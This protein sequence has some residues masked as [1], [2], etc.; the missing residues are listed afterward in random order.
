MACKWIV[1]K[2][3][4][5]PIEFR[6]MLAGLPLEKQLVNRI[7][8]LIALKAV[9]SESY[10]HQGEAPLFALMHSCV[11]RAEAQRKSLPASNGS[12]NELDAF[13][14]TMVHRYDD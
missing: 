9:Q 13:F 2:E 8:E 6:K 7:E 10:L 1:E 12:F 11:E 5:P 14:L 4:M 3:Q